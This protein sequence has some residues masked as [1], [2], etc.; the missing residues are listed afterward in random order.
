[1]R[2]LTVDRVVSDREFKYEDSS[3]RMD[4]VL[5]LS[6]NKRCVGRKQEVE[7]RMARRRVKKSVARG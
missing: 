1:M 2:W 7:V 4:G 3:V 5:S 6:S